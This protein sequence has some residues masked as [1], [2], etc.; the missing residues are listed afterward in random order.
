MRRRV[1]VLVPFVG[2]AV[3]CMGVELIVGKSQQ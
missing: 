2:S 1:N 3:R